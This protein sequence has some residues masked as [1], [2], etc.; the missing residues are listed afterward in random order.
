LFEDLSGERGTY[1]EESERGSP[2]RNRTVG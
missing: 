2:W 1:G